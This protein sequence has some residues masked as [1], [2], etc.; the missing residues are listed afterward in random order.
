MVSLVR[1]VVLLHAVDLR[2]CSDGIG[3]WEVAA[4]LRGPGYTYHLPSGKLTVRP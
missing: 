4:L 3:G 2:G 1:P